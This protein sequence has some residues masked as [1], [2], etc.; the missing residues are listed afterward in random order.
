MDGRLPKNAFMQVASRGSP[1]FPR[2]RESSDFRRK[3]LVPAFAGTTNEMSSGRALSNCF[4][5]PRGSA[6]ALGHDRARITVAAPDAHAPLLHASVG[7]THRRTCSYIPGSAI[8]R[9]R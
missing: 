2:R 1:S 3:T 5:D 6:L 8:S 9:C 4:F 7:D